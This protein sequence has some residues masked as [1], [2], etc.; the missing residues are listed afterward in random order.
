VKDRGRRAFVQGSLALTGLALL[1]GCGLPS[2]P[3]QP[4][5]KISRIGY[6]QLNAAPDDLAEDATMGIRCVSRRLGSRG[7]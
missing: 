3:W 6:L 7:G 5:P 2:L 1:S 4:P